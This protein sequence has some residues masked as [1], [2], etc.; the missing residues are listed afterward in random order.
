MPIVLNKLA[1]TRLTSIT[2]INDNYDTLEN[3]INGLEALDLDFDKRLDTIEVVFNSDDFNRIIQ[4][5]FYETVTKVEDLFTQNAQLVEQANKTLAELQA[6]S[7]RTTLMVGSGQSNMAS[8]AV[9][10]VGG[11]TTPSDNVFLRQWDRNEVTKTVTGKWV[12]WTPSDSYEVLPPTWNGSNWVSYSSNRNNVLFQTAKEYV[13]LNGGNVYCVLAARGGQSIE[14][15]VIGSADPTS[16]NYNNQARPI[17]DLLDQAV[18]DAIT[19][20]EMVEANKT[21]IDHFIWFQGEADTAYGRYEQEVNNLT[22]SLNGASWFKQGG[23]IVAAE[24]SA[25]FGQSDF[26]VHASQGA[27]YQLSTVGTG[28]LSFPDN[29]HIAGVDMDELGYRFASTL[30]GNGSFLARDVSVLRPRKGQTSLTFFIGEAKDAQWQDP[31]ALIQYLNTKDLQEVGSVNITLATGY[32]SPP[33]DFS[34]LKSSIPVVFR[35][36]STGSFSTTNALPANFSGGETAA[37]AALNGILSSSVLGTTGST[38]LI[39][40]GK[41]PLQVRSLLLDANSISTIQNAVEVVGSSDVSLLD[42]GMIGHTGAALSVV[43]SSSVEINSMVAYGGTRGLDISGGQLS[44]GGFRARIMTFVGQTSEA[45][46]FQN[47][48]VTSPLP[49]AY[50]G[51][52]STT[53]PLVQVRTFSDVKLYGIEA[54][55]CETVWAVNE[56][57]KLLI[58]AENPLAAVEIG[59]IT[60]TGISATVSSGSD[61]KILK[62]LNVGTLNGRLINCTSGSVLLMGTD[63]N[64][65][66]QTANPSARFMLAQSQGSSI[67]ITGTLTVSGAPNLTTSS[68]SL[69]ATQGGVIRVGSKVVPA[70][71]GQSPATNGFDSTGTGIFV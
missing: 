7:Q 25:T 50:F 5:S 47:G 11:D 68:N 39:K 20:I 44:G 37:R 4:P 12:V 46:S 52:C 67:T 19:S 24:L 6:A 10:A 53:S 18:T 38:F 70:N 54:D 65:T 36:L 8:S 63:V 16:P 59:T 49:R 23:R 40:A 62:D 57:S 34:L 51:E 41:G 29:V 9:E 66:T 43:G 22:E 27:N 45:L 56:G 60:T 42:V 15:W 14:N 61:V 33:V 48:A 17:W 31:N 28:D 55:T 30:L 64:I 32:S 69:T 13:R 21:A 71:F 26:W 35:A 1:T 2:S 58:S 3:Y